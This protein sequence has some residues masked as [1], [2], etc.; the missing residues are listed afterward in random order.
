[1]G[2]SLRWKCLKKCEQGRKGVKCGCP[3]SWSYYV[4]FY[5]R[6][7][8]N[9]RTLSRYDDPGAKF[10][11]FKVGSRSKTVARQQ[12]AAI[13]TRLLQGE[14][15]TPQ[16]QA[17]PIA[18][19][20][21]IPQWLE[22]AKLTLAARTFANY[23]Q[24]L[25]LYILPRLGEQTVSAITWAQV[26]VLLTE[27]QQAGLSANTVRLIRAVL[28]SILTDAAE[29]G[30]IPA[31]PVLG[32]RRKRRGKHTSVKEVSPLNWEQKAAF[33][34]QLTQLERENLLS[35]AYATLLRVYLKAG[36]RPSEGRA[37]K[38]GDIDFLGR[39]LRVERSATLDGDTKETKTGEA[40]WVDLSDGL[41]D[42]LKSYLTG[43]RAEDLFKGKE[44]EWLFP[45][46]TGT[47]LDESHVVRAFHRVLETAGLPRFRVY[48]LRHTFASLLLSSN[49]PLLYVG[50]QLGHTK[51]TITLKYYARWIP[52]G[53]VH[54]VNVLD[55][56]NP[57]NTYLTLAALGGES[58][59]VVHT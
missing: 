5:V 25:S 3:K 14:D 35:P 56:N 24:L 33:E 18:L 19:K 36:L 52:S 32:Q 49:Q 22:Q 29:E 39:R 9:R 15:I 30:L 11:R 6:E 57:L 40:R 48:D 20:D 34:Q 43:L 7:E 31:N 53:Q 47:L 27:K 55:A 1:M 58:T 44:S 51:P 17:K 50:Q 23:R 46:E 28:S 13:K 26:R 59:T 10:K 2:L 42:Q 8:D 16:A 41:L 38:P 37:L 12:E 21:Y 4:E 45:S 54:R